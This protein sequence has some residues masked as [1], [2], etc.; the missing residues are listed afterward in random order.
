[1]NAFWLAQ[2]APLPT[3]YKG[4]VFPAD[5]EIDMATHFSTKTYLLVAF[6]VLMMFF[7]FAVLIY[8][9]E[10]ERRRSNFWPEHPVHHYR[11][12]PKP[13]RKRKAPPP[14]DVSD[15]NAAL[16]QTRD[17]C[18]H[19]SREVTKRKCRRIVRK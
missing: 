15:A 18:G 7:A 9:K 17:D 5:D 4:G 12:L 13:H 2:V 1:M 6:A 11:V 19:V 16:R 14:S 3:R 8:L 10:K